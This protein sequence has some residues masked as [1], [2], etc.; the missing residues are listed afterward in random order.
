MAWKTRLTVD[1]DT[2]ASPEGLGERH[3]HAA[4]RQTPDESGDDQ[5]L[6]G[7]GPGHPLSEQGE[8][9]SPAVAPQLR[10]H[11]HHR[12]GSGPNRQVAVD[13]ARPARVSRPLCAARS[14]C[15]TRTR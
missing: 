15:G 10:A 1:L 7:V 14:G 12:A 6:Q 5:G 2:V 3:L 8:A 9:N 13:V 4:D 11:E